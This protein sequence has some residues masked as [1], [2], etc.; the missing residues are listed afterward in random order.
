MTVICGYEGC[1]NEVETDGTRRKYCRRCAPNA[2]RDQQRI[3]AG[4][5]RERLKMET[6]VSLALC[7]SV[8]ELDSAPDAVP[9]PI[10]PTTPKNQ[11]QPLE[12]GDCGC[13]RKYVW[14]YQRVGTLLRACGKCV[15]RAEL[16]RVAHDARLSDAAWARSSGGLSNREIARRA[17]ER[18]EEQAA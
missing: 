12:R 14:L 17:R 9:R 8:T 5:R 1:T 3:R 11:Y 7:A 4:R 6:A 13:G 16:G 10:E 15:M 18:D 2:N